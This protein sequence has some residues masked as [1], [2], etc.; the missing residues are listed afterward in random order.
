MKGPVLLNRYFHRF[1]DYMDQLD[2]VLTP[3]SSV[4]ELRQQLQAEQQRRQVAEAEAAALRLTA[5]IPLRNPN[6]ILRLS[7]NGVLEFANNTAAFLR[8]EFE[9]KGHSWVRTQLLEA[10]E[11]AL[12]SGQPERR[13]LTIGHQHLVLVTVPV[14]E[15]GYAMLYFNDVTGLHQ[16]ETQLQEQHAFYENLLENLPVVVT[17]LGPDQRYRFLNHFAAP[18][19]TERQAR[20]GTT[21]ADHCARVGLPRK[22]AARRRRLFERAATRRAL[23]A[24]EEEW[25]ATAGPARHW[26]CYYQ[27]VFDP[28]GHLRVMMCFGLDVSTQ[29]RAEEKSRASEAAVR[30]QQRFT[31]QV[32]N[33]NP[34]II[35]VRDKQMRF[36]FE[37]AATARLRAVMVARSP[38]K[39]PGTAL[40][41][42]ELAAYAAVDAAVRRTNAAVE[43][44]DRMT[45][46]DGEV[47]WYQTVKCPLPT[48]EG[49]I[50]VLG[51]STDITAL[52]AAQHAAEAAATA[53]ENFL[54]NMSHEIRTPLN[55]VLGMAGL[56]AKTGL[57]AQQRNF[58]GIIEQ[59]GQHLLGVV[60]DVLDM[61]KITSGKLDMEAVAFNLCDCMGQALEPLAAL[62]QQKGLRV[63]GTMLRDSCPHPWVVGD[64]Q[65]LR[66]IFINLVSNAVKFT[67]AGGTITAGGYF[68]RETDDTLTTEFRVA[69]TGIGISPEKLET[70]FQEFTQAYAD[71]TRQFGGTGLGLSISRALV[72]QLGGRLTVQ[73]ELGQG[74]TFAFE[75]TL[76]KATT[77]A[78][79]AVLQQAPTAPAALAGAALAGRRV[80]L[81]E[82]NAVNREVAQLLL[83]G[84]G[85]LVDTAESGLEALEKFETRHYDLVLMDIQMPGM[86]GLDATA[87]IRAHADAR[88]AATPILALTANAFKADAEKYLAA[89]M[90]DALAKP[91]AEAELVTKM[92]ALLGAAP[93]IGPVAAA[94]APTT[95]PTIPTDRADPGPGPETAVFDLALLRETAHGSQPFMTRILASFHA[96][97]P[98]HLNDLWAAV[99]TADVPAA[100]ALAHKLRPSLSLVGAAALAPLLAT[101]ED[102]T[103]GPE[104]RTA[105]AMH[106][107][108][109]IEALL[110]A[111]PTAA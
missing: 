18:N 11:K 42:E 102:E 31:E 91:F 63:I 37:N 88:R 41:P 65:R 84:H 21:F 25:P 15:E 98:V 96:N 83:E 87:R 43:S 97:T 95:A 23:V 93:S 73:S 38:D 50:H 107:A 54:A 86:N 45:L 6:P 4:A 106:L 5:S 8:S 30:A 36:V 90:N 52:K 94:P 92:A 26:L 60:N 82:D 16:A 72:Q 22:F 35:Y 85:V 74:S 10:V 53:R 66:Q 27:P 55:G 111:L 48:P 62:A 19:P 61:A 46:G 33:L 34:N 76:P 100:A 70:I 3:E 12:T 2:E 64:P 13:A 56:L 9:R 7:A 51:V 59:S 49:E 89:G 79:Q 28:D 58:V 68:V 75:V 71:T 67:P 39:I 1:D 99:G 47:R 20:V 81:V 101:I 44:E 103:A 104:A 109:G 78:V 14:A 77:A 29:R 80:L 17:V 32:L 57:S 40:R 69:D 24:W 105:A 110:A 108:E